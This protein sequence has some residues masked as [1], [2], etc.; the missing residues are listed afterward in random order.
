M[1]RHA[2]TLVPLVAAALGWSVLHVTSR[3][4][5]AAA[6]PE[7]SPPAPAATAEAKTDHTDAAAGVEARVRALAAR[8]GADE[9]AERERAQAELSSIGRDAEPHLRR[10]LEADPPPDLETRTRIRAVLDATEQDRRTGATP[11]TLRLAGVS[12]H[13]AFAAFAKQAGIGLADG[14]DRMLLDQAGQQID[15]DLAGVPM[16]Q[17]LS[18]LSAQCNLAFHEID[19][20]GRL[21]LERPA[22]DEVRAPFAS[23][24]PFAITISRVET[25]ATR[26]VDFTGRRPMN[27]DPKANRPP[28]FRLFANAWA[29]PRLRPLLWQLEGLQPEFAAR[30]GAQPADANAAPAND[31][32]AGPPRPPVP[33]VPFGMLGGGGPVNAPGDARLELPAEGANNARAL[34]RLTLTARFVL[35]RGERQKVDLPD[36]LNVKE[37]QQLVLGVPVVINGVSHAGGDEYS[38]RYT[39]RRDRRQMQ[40]WQLFYSILDR[41]PPRVVDAEG[42][43]LMPR[44]SSST[45]GGDEF[46]RTATVST[47]PFGRAAGAVGPPARLAWEYPG[48][49]EQVPVKLVFE[50]VPLP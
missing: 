13:E 23:D 38:L 20:E 3:P 50:D 26:A 6:E 42:R 14:T 11:V 35:E 33:G 22:A 21:V 5:P 32:G 27:A 45:F 39:A 17:A 19:A 16:W 4:S 12:P 15:V 10:L 34:R 25:T 37:H 30:P 18:K 41:F 48:D 24:G 8:L 29:E 9:A 47:R 49:I 43:A 28:S 7:G 36:V 31:D 40:Q 2:R 44:G 46:T 1:N